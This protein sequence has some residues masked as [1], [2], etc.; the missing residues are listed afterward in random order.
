MSKKKT[1]TSKPLP[2]QYIAINTGSDYVISI[3]D[4]KYVLDEVNSYIEIEECDADDIE[5]DIKVFELGNMVEMFTETRTRVY[6]N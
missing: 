6:F 1:T 5:N 4:L 2:K 3:G